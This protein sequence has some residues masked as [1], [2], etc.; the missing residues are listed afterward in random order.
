DKG[1]ALNDL[2]EIASELAEKGRNDEAVVALK[3]AAELHPGDEDVKDKLLDVY[4][5]AGDFGNARACA[6]SL[7]QFRMVAAA[8]EGGG[9]VDARDTRRGAASQPDDTDLRPGGAKKLTARGDATPA[10]EYLTAET[11]GDDPE[12]LLLVADIKLRGDAMADGVEIV[13]KLLEQDA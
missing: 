10:A 9:D 5:A 6:T 7:E 13:R 2:K 12:L 1:G 3:Q 4:F 8:Q 11:A